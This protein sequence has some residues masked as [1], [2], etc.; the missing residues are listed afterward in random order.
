MLITFL[1]S[2]EEGGR[3]PVADAEPSVDAEARAWL[4]ERHRICSLETAGP[5]LP[6]DFDAASWGALR[7]YS[8]CRFLTYRQ[9]VAET[10]RKAFTGE[11]P[12]ATA[13]SI[14]GVD[15]LLRHLPELWKLAD[16]LLDDDPL[17]DELKRL[18]AA[19]PLSSV[20]MPDVAEPDLDPIFAHA[21]LRQLY[22]DRVLQRRDRSRL[23]DPRVLAGAREAVGDQPELRP[24]LAGL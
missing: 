2:L 22:I 6:F 19:W 14:F 23:S 3:T 15:L 12:K 20:G 13:S 21:G 18:A 1:R 8:A 5:A 16:D 7:L 4:A 10:V 17:I 9:E 24:L 11:G